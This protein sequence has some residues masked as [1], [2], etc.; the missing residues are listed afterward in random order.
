MGTGLTGQF[1][2][3]SD[4][5]ILHRA[6]DGLRRMMPAPGGRTIG[7]DSDLGFLARNGGILRGLGEGLWWLGGD[8]R[9]CRLRGQ[10]L[11]PINHLRLKNPRVA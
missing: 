3:P 7:S 2:A 1:A 6:K 5:R 8:A 10:G 4:R 9:F 11:S